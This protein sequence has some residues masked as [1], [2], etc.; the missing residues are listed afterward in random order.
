M[1]DRSQVSE[2]IDTKLFSELLLRFLSMIVG[3]W[4]H[5]CAGVTTEPTDHEHP[6]L[7]SCSA[8]LARCQSPGEII[9]HNQDNNQCKSCPQLHTAL[10][11][12]SHFTLPSTWQC[13]YQQCVWYEKFRG[14]VPSWISIYQL[15]HCEGILS[16]REALI[17]CGSGL[18]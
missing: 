17:S 15:Q 7:R 6:C 4:H 3:C 1:I 5:H 9:R 16:E 18:L 13:C 8:L 11:V 12:Y 2:C 10:P 14:V